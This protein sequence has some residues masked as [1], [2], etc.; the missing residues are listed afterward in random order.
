MSKLERKV[1]KGSTIIDNIEVKGESLILTIEGLDEGYRTIDILFKERRTGNSWSQ[2]K[3]LETGNNIITVDLKNFIKKHASTLSRWDLFIQTE[4]KEST[5]ENRLGCFNEKKKPTHVRYFEPIETANSNVIAPYLTV[6]N[7][8]S[9]VIKPLTSLHKEILKSNTELIDLDFKKGVLYGE[10]MLELSECKDFFVSDILLR[11]RGKLNKLI[12]RY[13]IEEETKIAE[14]SSKSTFKID[15]RQ[16]E[17]EPFYW[18]TFLVV[19]ISSKE[20]FVRIQNL[21]ESLERK[22]YIDNSRYTYESKNGFLVYPYITKN[23]TLA[24]TYR[25]KSLYE[26]RIYKMK[27]KIASWIYPIVS[28][29]L[30]KKQIWL[31]YEKFSETAQDNAFYFFKYLYNNEKK[32]NVYYI[33]DKSSPDY[34]NMKGMKDRVIPFMSIKHFLYLYASKLLVSSEARNHCYIFRKQNG[35]M[36]TVIN[37]KKFVYL[38]HGVIGFKNMGSLFKKTG[39]GDPDLYIASSELEKKIIM[40]NLKYDEEEVVITGLSRWDVLEDQSKFKKKKE[41]LLMPTWRPWLDDVSEERFVNSDYYHYYI[42]LLNSKRLKQLLENKNLMMNFYIH[43]KFMDHI[44]K[45]HTKSKHIK[46]YKFGEEKVNKLIMDCSLLITDYS[47]VAW[48][49]LYQGKPTI[50]YQFDY[51]DYEML[52]GSYIDM[53]KDLFGDR[54]LE[55]NDLINSINDYSDNDFREKQKYVE[56]RITLFTYIDKNNSS[57][58]YK[59]ILKTRWN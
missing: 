36:K 49:Q 21:P 55:E 25:K 14:K 31:M 35:E 44:N 18:D 24:L 10:V 42:N 11:H 33:I 19:N 40:E 54:V 13:S 17:L 4:S 20:Y 6:K 50:F 29:Y 2:K 28:G 51:K 39:N 5:I 53:T 48:D 16:L 12:F 22:V 32:R 27:E 41:I 3:L 56:M 8:L 45:F 26:N 46:I 23:H 9:L 38:R 37:R 47:S 7:G 43:P 52:Q 34:K 57:R 15:F 58:I 59:E 30:D 1:N